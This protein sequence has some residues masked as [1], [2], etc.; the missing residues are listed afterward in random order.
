MNKATFVTTV[1]QKMLFTE[2]KHNLSKNAK[3][4]K[5]CLTPTPPVNLSLKSTLVMS[6][7]VLF[8]NKITAGK[9]KKR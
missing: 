2:S 5:G 1:Y 9:E 7:S 3:I 6:L 4:G 8:S